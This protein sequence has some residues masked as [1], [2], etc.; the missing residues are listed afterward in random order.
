MYN[1]IILATGHRESGICNSNE[2]I[3]IIAQIAPDIIFEE[4]PPKKFDGVYKGSISDSLETK[5]IKR[6]LHKHAIDHFPVDQDINQLIENRFRRDIKEL[7]NIIGYHSPE[8]NDLS[9]QHAIMVEQYGFPYL[10]SDQ[11]EELLERRRLLE[12]EIVRIINHE[13][14]SQK[15]KGWLDYI[16]RRENEMINNI[17]KYS[18]LHKYNRALFLIGAEHRKPIMDKLPKYEKNNKPELNWIFNYFK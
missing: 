12:E 15:H 7:D 5:T 14:I 2:L 11:C 1:I 17:Y 6:Y 8:Y 13:Q 3:K 9:D 16:N 4:V 18:A 10:N